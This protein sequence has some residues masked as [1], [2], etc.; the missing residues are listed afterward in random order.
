MGRKRRLG[1]H[2]LF[3]PSILKRIVD[4]SGISEKDLVVE[5]G[6]GYGGLT[7]FLAERAGRLIAIEIDKRLW[8][9]LRRDFIDYKNV[10]ILHSDALKFPYETLGEF[11]VVSNIPY[12][13]TTPL[14]FRLIESG[15]DL[16]SMTLTIQKE[17]AERIVAVFGT[18]KY[19]V[20]SVIL[21]YKGRPEIKFYIPKDAFRPVPR[22][23]SA[24]INIEIFREPPI[25]VLDEALFYK[26][27]RTAFSHRRKMLYNSLRSICDDIKDILISLDIEPSRRPETLRLEEFGMISNAISQLR[28]RTKD[29]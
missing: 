12:Y 29:V 7:R 27:I 28:S 8:E 26:V 11:R 5:I 23:D 21:Q 2:F 14:I 24:V 19:G 16:L 25:N 17:V 3:D 22:V 15:R 6:P 1:Q 13:I 20:L 10:E 9:N 18:K 4:V